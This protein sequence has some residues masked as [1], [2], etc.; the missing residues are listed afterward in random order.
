MNH[1]NQGTTSLASGTTESVTVEETAV[2]APDD[3]YGGTG[4]DVALLLLRLILATTIGAHGLI[5]VFGFLGGPGLSS[6]AQV[7]HGY[8]FTR[9]ITL[10]SWVTG[11]TEVGAS[12]MLVLGLATPLA[13]AGVLGVQLS[14]VWAKHGGGFF[15]GAGTGFEFELTLVV[16]ALVLLLAG[17]GRLSLDARTPWGRSPLFFG[18]AGL[19]VAILASIVINLAF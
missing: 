1:G 15:E 9:G 6:F 4:L 14:V 3:R 8:G 5:K 2:R 11:L 13:A 12:V 17:A 10:L 16:I 7:L 19:L 18:L